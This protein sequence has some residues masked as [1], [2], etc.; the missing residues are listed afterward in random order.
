MFTP[1]IHVIETADSTDLP[2]LL[3]LLDV[4]GLPQD[5]VADHIENALIVR[6]GDEI[7]GC[8]VLE[9][10]GS[11]ALLRSVAVSPT[12]QGHGLGTQLVDAALTH[13]QG[14]QIQRIY[15]LTETAA[16]YF[17]R[18]GFA[19]IAREDVDPSVKKSV[20]FTSACPASALV[21]VKMI[22]P[23]P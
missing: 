4:V 16:D 14:R 17:P 19:P 22:H 18:F 11:S 9:I 2:S 7:L 21:M 15:L 20:E 3:A 1:P 12:A 6:N 13:A 8:A 23:Y 10:Y 5:G